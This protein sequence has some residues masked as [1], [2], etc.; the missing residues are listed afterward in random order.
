LLEPAIAAW[1]GADLVAALNEAGVPSGRANT[2]P[3]ALADPQVEARQMLLDFHEPEMNGLR[4]LGNPIK[5]SENGAQPTRRPPRLGEHTR[6][7]LEELGYGEG[8]IAAF[9]TV[10]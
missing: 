7:V 9:S 8:E 10:T 2:V 3:E 4:V 5:L 1:T 6:E